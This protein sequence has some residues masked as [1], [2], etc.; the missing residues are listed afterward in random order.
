MNRKKEAAGLVGLLLALVVF[1]SAA[2]NVVFPKGIHMN[3]TWDLWG[4]YQQE[5]AET[6]DA[7]IMGN[8]LTYCNVIPAQI[9]EE[10]GYTSYVVGGPQQTLAMSWYALQE[11][12]K[13]QK[14][15]AIFLEMT[16]FYYP[17]FTKYA[18]GIIGS[19]PWTENRLGATLNAAPRE[20]WFSLFFPLYGYH[21]RWD[22]LEEE[23]YEKGLW[24]YT[25]DM[26][27]GYNYLDLISHQGEI[28]Q[29]ENQTTPESYE[30]NLEYFD[31]IAVFCRENDIRLRCFL[32]PGHVR[33]SQ[34]D[35]EEMRR[36]LDSYD[37][38]L[39]DYNEEFETMGM[40]GSVDYY[41]TSHLTFSGAQ[42]FT[43]N[44]ARLVEETLEG[45]AS[46]GGEAEELWAQRVAYYHALPP[47]G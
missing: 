47:V 25:E 13:T 15:S 31:K 21:D 3:A 2:S 20:D 34:A 16:C 23:D 10:T 30:I 9:Y 24:G 26:L 12:V 29:R 4:P 38:S 18:K 5:P 28:T 33:F 35:L 39:K 45:T 44:F 42:R 46:Q 22:E 11:A 8:S 41:D 27:A 7:F 43:G 17:Q 37:L 14:P 36:V 6:I 19:M 1:I 40:D 32:S